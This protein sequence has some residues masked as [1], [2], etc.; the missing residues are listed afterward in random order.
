MSFFA[1]KKVKN[2]VLKI[3]LDNENLDKPLTARQVLQLFALESGCVSIET[4]VLQ[5]TKLEDVAEE[6]RGFFYE[7]EL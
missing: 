1:T 5:S 2:K 6:I 7:I 3:A 4:A